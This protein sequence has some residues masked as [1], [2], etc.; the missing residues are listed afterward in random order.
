[1]FTWFYDI[2][3]AGMCVEKLLYLRAEKGEGTRGQ[4]QPSESHLS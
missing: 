3:K 4:V 1:M 2:M